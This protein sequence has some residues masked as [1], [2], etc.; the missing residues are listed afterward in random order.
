MN[1]ETKIGLKT[2]D[3]EKNILHAIY[4]MFNLGTSDH[5]S[6]NF[7]SYCVFFPNLINQ[8]NN[9]ELI[10]TKFKYLHFMFIFCT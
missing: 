6:F 7:D 4:L 5:K 1:E 8:Q 10:F 2:N 9:F 3:L